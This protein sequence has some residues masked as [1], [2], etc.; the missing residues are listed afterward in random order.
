MDES[1]QE[2]LQIQLN[3]HGLFFQWK[4]FNEMC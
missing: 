3:D 4:V 1:L 2:K